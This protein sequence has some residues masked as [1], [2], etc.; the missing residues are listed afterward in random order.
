MSLDT[1]IRTIHPVPQCWIFVLQRKTVAFGQIRLPLLPTQAVILSMPLSRLNGLWLAGIR[2]EQSS[3][4]SSLLM[5]AVIK[6]LMSGTADTF[7][8][9]YQPKTGQHL[10][11]LTPVTK[12]D[13]I[14]SDRYMFCVKFLFVDL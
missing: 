5:E 14:I 10:I 13:K 12:I 6:I 2:R 7:L 3:L 9:F 1:A 8:K 4:L 11:K